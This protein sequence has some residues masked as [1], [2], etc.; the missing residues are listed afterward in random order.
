M[1]KRQYSPQHYP[2]HHYNPMPDPNLFVPIGEHLQ[3]LMAKDK[4][5]V[6]MAKEAVDKQMMGVPEL[7]LKISTY[8]ERHA[9]LVDQ[10]NK[11]DDTVKTLGLTVTSLTDRV[12]NNAWNTLIT[13]LATA[14]ISG[15]AVIIFKHIMP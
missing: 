6:L 4:E 14:I 10:I 15:G 9:S 7:F 2:R 12:N 11:V 1:T 5:M 13:V 8:E 3:E